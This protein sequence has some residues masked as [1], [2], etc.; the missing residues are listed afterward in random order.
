MSCP[1]LLRCASFVTACLL[2]LSGCSAVQAVLSG[3]SSS[4]PS[5]VRE[6]AA[7]EAKKPADDPD[8]NDP[9]ATGP[10]DSLEYGNCTSSE[11]RDYDEELTDNDEEDS[12]AQAEV[13]VTKVIPASDQVN[14]T[15][16][17]LTVDQVVKVSAGARDVTIT[18]TN[19]VV[20]IEGEIESLTVHGFNNT[21]WIDAARK[22]TFG[23]SDDDNLNH[24]FWHSTPPQS[25]VD[26]QGANVVG[27]DIHAP[28]IRSCSVFS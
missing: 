15:T 19:L 13:Q 10:V 12:R 3:S 4:S 16:D 2:A 11:V 14:V 26:P 24:V 23:S 20:I 9:D 25:K 7:S 28:V 22:V 21:I 1:P 5:H 18:A 17:G 8:T 27:K 6:T